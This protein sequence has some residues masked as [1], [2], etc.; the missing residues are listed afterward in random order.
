MT[1]S[2]FSS[3]IDR[4]KFSFSQMDKKDLWCLYIGTGILF[5]VRDMYSNSKKRLLEYRNGDLKHPYSVLIKTEWDACIDGLRNAPLFNKHG[6]FG[7]LL[8]PLNFGIK[9]IDYAINI[10]PTTV[11]FLNPPTQNSVK[12]ITEESNEI[13]FK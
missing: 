13:T 5:Y 1:K 4:L 7:P 11:L 8:W 12:E 10:I 3:M 2:M 9:F 6:I